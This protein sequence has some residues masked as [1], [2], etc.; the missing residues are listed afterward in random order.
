M[1]RIEE[2][3]R[4]LKKGSSSV[5]EY[6]RRF[7]EK[8]SLVGHVAPTEKEMIKA[9]LKGLPADM[10]SRVRNAKAST[11]R[12]TIEKAKIIEDV[13]AQD[14]AEKAQVR[15]KRKWEGQ[16]GSSQKVKP[17][18]KNSP[19][20]EQRREPN[21]CPKCRNKH[22]VLVIFLLWNVINAGKV[23]IRLRTVQ[24]RELHV[25]NVNSQD[26]SEEIVLN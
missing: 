8:L 23:G 4:A 20:F 24:F 12:E 19:I 22:L 1:D 2:E 5:R 10:M 21:W 16:S 25:L 7:L 18:I 6:K 14:K 13:Y 15:E 3:F 11:L 17:F 9:Y 26:I